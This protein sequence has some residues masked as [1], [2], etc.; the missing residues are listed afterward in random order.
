MF[1]KIQE[2]NG[3]I[4]NNEWIEWDHF[5]VPNGPKELREII[6]Y[7]FSLL[8]HCL[9]CTALD[10]CYLVQRNMPE[11]PLH[12]M[13]DCKKIEIT[14]HQVKKKANAECSILKFT[15]YVFTDDF[16]SKGKKS[17]F[18]SLGFS[19]EDS[20]LLKNEIEKQGLSNYLLG[21]YLLKN[22]DDNGQRLA[23]PVILS[24]KTFYTGWMLEPEGKIRNTTPFGGWIK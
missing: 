8:G 21:N 9:K 14:S 10:G 24:G 17:I 1:A 15:K 20:F 19:S 2:S 7:I 23:I 6:R 5:G 18:E 3:Q 12:K 22:L 4:V 16:I 11:F 13:C